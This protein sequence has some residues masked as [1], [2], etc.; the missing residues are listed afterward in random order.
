LGRRVVQ[1]DQ[2]RLQFIRLCRD[3]VYSGLLLRL[4]LQ[5]FFT[6]NL[7][8]GK[9]K[10]PIFQ[11]WVV[12]RLTWSCFTVYTILQRCCLVTTFWVTYTEEWESDWQGRGKGMEMMGSE[13]N[14][15][16][17]GENGVYLCLNFGAKSSLLFV[18]NIWYLLVV[19]SFTPLHTVRGIRGVSPEEGKQGYGAPGRREPHRQLRHCL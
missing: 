18:A 16:R 2:I 19:A 6:R 3:I 15:E 8:A 10:W 1:G 14:M 11:S 13:G 9:M 17:G 7:S 12:K 5:S 4:I